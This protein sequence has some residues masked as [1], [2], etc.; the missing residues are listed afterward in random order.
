MKY[1]L[2]CFAILL[3]ACNSATD[4]K[5]TSEEK[6]MRVDSLIVQHPAPVVPLSTLAADTGKNCVRGA[7]VPVIKKNIFP[8]NT[9]Q[10][11]ADKVTGMETVELDKGDKLIIKQWG[12]DYY[13]LTLRFETTRF[14]NE[15]GNVGFWYKRA[16]TFVNEVA[17]GI[18][19]PVD[20]AKAT[21]A[22]AEHIEEDVPN[23]YRNLKYGEE[24]EISNGAIREFVSIDKIEQ[25]NDK[26]FAI[27][28]TIARGPL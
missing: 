28:V 14:Q 21:E 3:F 13:A 27:E 1:M 10:L 20:L 25:V 4:N 24:I 7:A 9:F 2:L 8:K 5:P 15:I 17:K 22:I 19:A 18:D 12:C 11:Q 23:E 26:K 16:V 6:N